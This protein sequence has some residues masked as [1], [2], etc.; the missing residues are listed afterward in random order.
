MNQFYENLKG[1]EKVMYK[2]GYNFHKNH[3][4]GATEESAHQAGLNEISRLAKLKEDHAEPET[5]VDLSTGKTHKAN[6]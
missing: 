3:S 5:W 2:M 4:K 6:Y 1:V